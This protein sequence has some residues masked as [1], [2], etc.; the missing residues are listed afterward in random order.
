MTQK[1]NEDQALDFE[2][3]GKLDPKIRNQAVE[4]LKGF[5]KYIEEDSSFPL[6]KRKTLKE[7]QDNLM[8][9][10]RKD[11]FNIQDPGVQTAVSLFVDNLSRL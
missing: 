11:G 4:A 10:L 5:N 7:T 8:E 3:E 9:L 2:P 1:Y 6:P